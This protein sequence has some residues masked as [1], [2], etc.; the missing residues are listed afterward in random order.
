MAPQKDSSA[1]QDEV[2]W[3]DQLTDYDLAHFKT[4]VRL[5]DAAASGASYSEMSQD[6][7][8][9]DSETDKER[10]YRVVEAHLKRAQW[11][12]TQGYRQLLG[13]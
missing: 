1:F 7:F 10:A 11:M 4:Y 13:R 12:T 8:G 2:P 5:L 9:L 6:I 3:S